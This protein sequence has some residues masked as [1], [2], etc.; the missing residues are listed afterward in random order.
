MRT[1]SHEYLYF[2]AGCEVHIF[3]LVVDTELLF[4]LKKVIEPLWVQSSYK[5][6]VYIL[7]S[8]NNISHNFISSNDVVCRRE[9][10]V[11]NTRN[12]LYFALAFR[13]KEGYI[14]FCR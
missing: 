12:Y 5:F 2:D 14:L 11:K 9:I 6:T 10:Y 1:G 4:C 13:A 8:M 3:R 7:F